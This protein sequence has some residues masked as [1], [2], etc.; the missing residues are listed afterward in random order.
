MLIYP[1]ELL[2]LYSYHANE[3]SF[4]RNITDTKI[5]IYIYPISVS[6]RTIITL[7]IILFLPLVDLIGN[8]C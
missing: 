5:Y 8:T 6:I 7:L 1:P 3:N 4:H 2:E